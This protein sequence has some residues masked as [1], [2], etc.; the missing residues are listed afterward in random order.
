MIQRAISVRDRRL[1]RSVTGGWLPRVVLVFL[2]GVAG[3]SLWVRAEAQAA[4]PEA[5][6]TQ[7]PTEVTAEFAI[8]H[9]VLNPKSTG[10]LGDSYQ[11]V[12]NVGSTCVGG[13]RAPESPETS[14]GAEHEE[15]SAAVAPLLPNTKYTACLVAINAALEEALGPPVTFTTALPP[16]TPE[17]LPAESVA[18]TTATLHGVLNPH[19]KGE[20]GSY[21]FVVSQSDSTCSA[22]GEIRTPQEA[23]S[24]NTPEPVSADVEGLLPKT[25]YTFCLLAINAVGE[26]AFGQPV[27]FE[28]TTAPPIVS[29]ESFSD[30]G[31][32][33]VTVSAQINPGGE[34][35]TYRLEYGA[36]TLEAS[37]PASSTPLQVQQ[38]LTGL[39]PSTEYHYRF[40]AHN[41]L[42]T[43]EGLVGTFTTAATSVSS[44]AL[45]DDRAYELVSSASH[46]G[47]V[48]VPRGQSAGGAPE[49]V[50]TELPLRAAADGHAVAYVED[51]ESVGGNGSSDGTVG[52]EHIARRGTKEW[53]ATNINPPASEGET[54]REAQLSSYESF[55]DSLSFGF[56]A[57]TSQPVAAS[58]EPRGP[59]NCSVLYSNTTTDNRFHAL[60]SS[61]TTPGYCGA[62]LGDVPPGGGITLLFAGESETTSQL[63][64][65]TDA[66]LTADTVPAEANESNLYD[67]MGGVL[68][69]VNRLP[70]GEA[71]AHSTFGAPSLISRGNPPNFG[72]I[73]S[74]DG[75]RIVWSTL[76]HAEESG[77]VLEQPTALYVRVNAAQPQS[78]TGVAGECTVS[79]DACTIQIDAAEATAPEGSGGG[80]YWAAS[81][82]GSKLFFTD[83]KKLTEHSTAVFSNSCEGLEEGEAPPRLAG[84]DLYEYDFAKPAGQRLTDLTVD[85]NPADVLG[86]DVQGVLGASEDGS[87]VYF[88]SGGALES[89]ANSRGETPTTRECVKSG[90]RPEEELGHLP[91]GKG[92]NIYL[93]RAGRPLRYIAALSA[94]DNNLS[95]GSA[96][97]T[98]DW[99]ADM[100]SRTAEVSSDGTHLVLVSTQ[101][102][103]GYG[104]DV[105]HDLE[106]QEVF[107]YSA[108]S[109]RLSCASCDPGGAPPVRGTG[110]T[111]PVSSSNTFMHRWMNREGS[112]VFFDSRQPLAAADTNGAQDVYEWEQEGTPSCP[113]Q[114]PARPDNGCVF[115]LSGGQSSSNSYFIDASESGNDVFIAHRGRLDNADK[116]D[117]KVHL[118][119]VRVHGG[120]PQTSLACTGTGCQGV[121]PAPPA[122]ATPASATFSGIGNFLPA[123]P[124]RATTK[125]LTRKQRLAKALKACRKK[126]KKK[127]V[128]CERH[129]RQHYGVVKRHLHKKS[130]KGRK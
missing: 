11:F 58:A 53:E 26:Q 91:A 51:P 37:L 116:P 22:G 98:G 126:P 60:F 64:F 30:V 113:G 69:L 100:G 70:N 80:R 57:G 92:C 76:E 106:G 23:S 25:R 16:E 128:A 45:P 96:R 38:R 7:A 87:S 12:Y 59:T 94:V 105:L 77:I 120:F 54:A 124:A 74:A 75:S 62:I 95:T 52:N 17:T 40:V 49:D 72:N 104:G 79:A 81:S 97:L 36:G 29:D 31:S 1:R 67:S 21:Q 86:A 129:A 34:P 55:S 71:D 66:A 63:L 10:E 89:D 83:C 73:I 111:L 42:G 68:H 39:T 117:E 32:T 9:G 114:S 118:D 119:D 93:W 101:H 78:P 13:T 90:G 35:S 125:A 107:V 8:L 110:G 5:P 6:E 2:V 112:Q 4:A 41:A 130:T 123:T 24:G 3:A 109:N 46:V 56:M 127:R 18:G 65:Q 50:V 122:F 121:P 14:L 33:E 102:L 84:S 28:T 27:T 85:H 99:Q 44:S 115:L 15:V 88:V 103:T 48:Y 20:A 108:T 19:S 43:A 47:E 61:T 82:D